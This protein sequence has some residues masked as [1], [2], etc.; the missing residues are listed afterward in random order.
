MDT[1]NDRVGRWVGVCEVEMEVGGMGD[2]SVNWVAK[3]LCKA[4]SY[5]SLKGL[6]FVPKSF[7]TL[8]LYPVQCLHRNT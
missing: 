8:F 7:K 3:I 4:D 6:V 5:P 2:D 1:G